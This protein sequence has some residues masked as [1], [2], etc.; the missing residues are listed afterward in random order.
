MNLDDCQ[1]KYFD[2]CFEALRLPWLPWVGA[3]YRAAENKTIVLGESI[4]DYS[5]GDATVFNRIM[6]KESL[7]N[8]HFTHGLLARFKSRYLRNFE[9]AVF[10]KKRPGPEE[11]ALL[12]TQVVYH[13]LVPRMMTSLKQRPSAADYVA[14]WRMFFQLA[15]TVEA[16][17]CIVYGL[18]PAKIDALLE[19]LLELPPQGVPV[20]RK[21]LAPV[22]RNRPLLISLSIGGRPMDL[23]FIRHPSAFFQWEEWGAVLRAA[24]MLPT[25]RATDGSTERALVP[26]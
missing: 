1:D 4:Y 10:L 25:P 16:R 23:L 18:E 2:P 5:G 8:R 14:G 9:R 13:N 12:W 19:A 15:A 6:A 22:G 7:R 3:R 17:R 21:R 26:A 24:D 20:E 11:R